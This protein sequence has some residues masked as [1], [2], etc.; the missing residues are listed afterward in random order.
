[1]SQRAD[2]SRK[3]KSSRQTSGPEARQRAALAINA[4]LNP[5]EALAAVARQACALTGS[6]RS[7]V[8]L[9]GEEADTLQLV[10]GH[11]LPDGWLGLKLPA[12]QG[13][14]GT[15]LR[16]RSVLLA[17]AARE[18][19]RDRSLGQRLAV[20]RLVAHS[21]RLGVLQVARGAKERR[22]NSSDIAALEWFAPLAAQAIA[23]AQDFDRSVRTISQFQI[24]NETLL[25]MDNV[26][27]A[28]TDAGGHPDQLLIQS[29]ER[30]CNSLHLSGG[31]VRLYDE[32]TGKLETVVER[33][34]PAEARGPSTISGA[35]VIESP[36]GGTLVT[37]PL[38]ARERTVGF[39]QAMTAPGQKLN[40][41]DRDVLAIVANQLAL[42]IE[43]ARLFRR[44]ETNEQ[45]VRATLASTDNVVLCV[46][47]ER[48]LLAANAV[49]ERAFG[50]RA[51]AC[52][53]QPLSEIIQNQTLHLA[54][55]QTRYQHDAR[56]RT[57]QIP[58]SN[59]R[60]LFATLSPLLIR[61]GALQ[62]WVLVAQD[63]TH[64]KEIEQFRT[65]MILTT[66]HELRNPINLT[67]GAL[68]LLEKH[69]EA[70]T[71]AQQ[72]SLDLAKLGIERAAALIGDL[73]DL[74]HIERRIGMKMSRCD[75]AQ[76]LSSIGL[77]F[78]WWA[79]NHGMALQ[80]RMPDS[81]LIVWG[82]ERLLQRV[83]SNLVDNAF[84][85]TPPGGCVT[86]EA[87]TEA[88]QVIVE[89][90][91]TGPGIPLEAQ[92]YV[93]EQFFRL[94]DQPD[95]VKGT[96]L[97]LTIVKSIVEQHGGRVWVTSQPGQGA[98]FT[99]SLPAFDK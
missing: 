11:R 85:Y 58:L 23:N 32:R 40:S 86:I 57:F 75:C 98:T 21:K 22:F 31:A 80:V 55:D 76:L 59:E 52:A 48:R 16:G 77:E 63:I 43:N 27:R 20:V 53:G 93:F 37:L 83:M 28:V 30:A 24:S 91:D 96:G 56:R 87:R 6:Q 50:I 7:A 1:M 36:G 42:G 12:G 79:Q 13:V 78:R 88:G 4:S 34:L 35:S 66:S 54:M 51:E 99:V 17:N 41:D 97:G 68:E 62:G 3:S 25:A 73:L 70:P 10:A 65:D 45:Q 90:S 49:A 71:S 84:K 92:P 82:D 39:L 5:D 60:I 8:Y 33:N 47:A 74:E 72:E 9:L 19:E 14:V 38:V 95:G 64:S 81:P 29:F 69:L 26:A 44:V 2:S 89:V 67:S 46:D 18:P 15:A 94:P 61:G